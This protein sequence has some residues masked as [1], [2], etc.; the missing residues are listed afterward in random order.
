MTEEKR[1]PDDMTANPE[2]VRV[3]SIRVGPEDASRWSSL[4]QPHQYVEWIRQGMEKVPQEYKRIATLTFRVECDD[5]FGDQEI[6]CHD[7]YM[8]L[9]Y[10]T[11][12]PR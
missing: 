3:D 6:V 8:D 9:E 5:L 2:I 1:E 11:G 7:I 12:T 4:V 10:Y